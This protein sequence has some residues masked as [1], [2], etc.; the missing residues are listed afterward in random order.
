M[1]EKIAAPDIPEEEAKKLQEFVS[2]YKEN[3]IEMRAN[4]DSHKRDFT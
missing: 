2:F 3:D 1:E 4:I